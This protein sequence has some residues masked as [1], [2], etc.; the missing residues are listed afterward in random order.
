MNQQ[1]KNYNISANTF[2]SVV[3]MTHANIVNAQVIS[4]H[5]STVSHSV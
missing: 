5:T 1:C 4:K 2:L 3:A